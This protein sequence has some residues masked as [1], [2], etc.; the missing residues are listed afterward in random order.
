MLLL[1]NKANRII[2][3]I[4]I[5][6]DTNTQVPTED[7]EIYL[8][9]PIF[10]QTAEDFCKALDMVTKGED[11]TVLMNSPGGSVFAGW[12]MIGRMKERGGKINCKVYGH[13]ASMSQYF[14]LFCDHV[15]ALEVTKFLIHR[16]DGYVRNEDD[17][18]FLDKINKEIRKHMETKLDIEVLESIA[19]VTMD[20]IFNGEEVKD[21]WLTAK[22]AKK[23]GLINKVN[24][25]APEELKAFNNRF[26]AYNRLQGSDLSQGSEIVQ[27][28]EIINNNLT[29]KKMTKAEFKAQN[30]ELYAEIFAEGQDFGKKTEQ[31][32]AQTWMAYMDIDKENVVASI[33][34]GKEFTTAVMAEMAVK[35]QSAATVKEIKADGAD[36][37]S[38]EKPDDKTAEQKAVDAEIAEVQAS[39]KKINIYA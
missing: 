3:K 36:P 20:D 21:V 8:M 1:R 25:M 31:V 13:A 9:S 12:T 37:I 33:K 32:R 23:I 10:E 16:A 28:S 11:V 7:N 24:R 15:E 19:G 35:M 4:K 27:E 18:K 17:Q 30:P 29:T 38:T 34:E 22:E 6:P 14:L 26:V 5:M 39:V 2:L